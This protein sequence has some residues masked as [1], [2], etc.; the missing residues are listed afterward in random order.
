ME[1]KNPI[2]RHE[3]LK[4]L[5][6]EHHHGLLLCWKIRQGIKFKTEPIRMK[7]Y[8]DWFKNEYL[9]PHFE[10]EEKYVFPVLGN[11]DPLIKKALAEHRRLRRLFDQQSDVLKA[12]SLIEEELD[13][14]IRFE[15]RIVFNEV[16]QIATPGE[17][18]DIEKNHHSIAF[19]DDA[20]QDHFWAPKNDQK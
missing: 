13:K 16:Q 3:A 15:E 7:S 18:K 19:S 11:E 14:H 6:R 1:K 17:F 12:L 20:W 4:A 10:A 9:Y 8:T 2:K 5:S